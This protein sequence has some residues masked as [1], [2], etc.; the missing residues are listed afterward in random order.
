MTM[1]QLRDEFLQLRYDDEL[2][3]EQYDA[4][5]EGFQA[6]LD[7]QCLGSDD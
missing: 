5:Q 7:D 2:F 3:A 4:T 6:W 1:Q